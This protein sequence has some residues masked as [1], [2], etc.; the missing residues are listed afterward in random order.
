MDIVLLE[1][2][3]VDALVCPVELSFSV[4]QPILVAPAVE[5]SVS[6]SL[7]AKTVLLVF[8]PLPF[9]HY[10]IEVDVLSLPMCLVV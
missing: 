1:L 4:F 6:P 7:L 10:A 5:R 9:V 3:S 8:I 2:P